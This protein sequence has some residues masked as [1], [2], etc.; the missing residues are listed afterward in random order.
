VPPASRSLARS[1]VHSLLAGLPGEA[2]VGALVSSVSPPSRTQSGSLLPGFAEQQ[3]G[4]RET[5]R[6][7]HWY[8]PE[9][10]EQRAC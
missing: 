7:S 10:Y 3:T 6:K 9:V 5:R 2:L 4:A 8:A 1:Y